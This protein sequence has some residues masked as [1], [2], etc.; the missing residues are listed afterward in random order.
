VSTGDVEIYASL[1]S[2][3]GDEAAE[4]SLSGAEFF[5]WIHRWETTMGIR[6]WWRISLIHLEP[7]DLMDN[8]G[9]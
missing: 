1:G 2:E 6:K 9:D 5:P 7:L 8:N 4:E 3:G